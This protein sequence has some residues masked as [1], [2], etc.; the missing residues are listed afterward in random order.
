VKRDIVK[1]RAA[2][3]R[4]AGEAGLSRHLDRQQGRVLSGLVERPGVARA[5][6][7]TEIAFVGE[8]PVG[9][10]VRLRVTGHDGRR[11][12]AETLAMEIA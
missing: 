4:A 11:V 10:I 1:A 8:A 9:E 6:D 5:E 7:F 2:E 3:L 12:V